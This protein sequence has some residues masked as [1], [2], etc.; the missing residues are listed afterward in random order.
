MKGKVIQ[1]C[2][3]LIHKYCM[4]PDLGTEEEL[5]VIEPWGRDGLRVRATLSSAVLDTEWAL[6]EKIVSKASISITDN[7]ATITNGII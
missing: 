5:L 6:T 3:Q 1:R 7:K 4:R 2:E